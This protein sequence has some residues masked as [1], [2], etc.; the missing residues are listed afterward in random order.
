M[1][2]K[3]VLC[4]SRDACLCESAKEVR[5]VCVYKREEKRAVYCLPM[6]VI[7]IRVDLCLSVRRSRFAVAS[8]GLRHSSEPLFSTCRLYQSPFLLI[9][10]L[11]RPRLVA[12]RRRPKLG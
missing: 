11:G 6:Y 8:R 7:H 1:L 5:A 10:R 3:A 9:E 2:G 4:D 12:S